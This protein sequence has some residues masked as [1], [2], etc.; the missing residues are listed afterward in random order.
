M[1]PAVRPPPALPAPACEAAAHLLQR[2]VLGI[3]R[4]QNNTATTHVTIWRRA[5]LASGIHTEAFRDHVLASTGVAV[6]IGEDYEAAGGE[7]AHVFSLEVDFERGDWDWV[8]D[9][10]P[11]Q[12]VDDAL[13]LIAMEL[14]RNEIVPIIVVSD[15]LR[16]VKPRH[17]PLFNRARSAPLAVAVLEVTFQAAGFLVGEKIM[18]G[19]THLTRIE[20]ALHIPKHAVDYTDDPRRD[21]LRACGKECPLTRRVAS[22]P[23]I[24]GAEDLDAFALF[25]A[26]ADHID[27]SQGATKA[28]LDILKSLNVPSRLLQRPPSHVRLDMVELEGFGPF[29]GVVRYPLSNRGVRIVTGMNKVTSGASSN[30]AGKTYL[31][32]AP[33]RALTGSIDT[34]PDSTKGLSISEVVH[35]S[36]AHARVRVE[37]VVNGRPSTIERQAGRKSMLLFVLDTE[38]RICQDM[39]LTQQC[40]DDLIDTLKLPCGKAECR[41]SPMTELQKE[42]CSRKARGYGVEGEPNGPKSLLQRKQN[43]SFRPKISERRAGTEQF[44]SV[45]FLPLSRL[46]AAA[47]AAVAA[48]SASA[49]TSRARDG[50]TGQLIPLNTPRSSAGGGGPAAGGPPSRGTGWALQPVLSRPPALPAPA[51]QAAAHLLQRVVLGIRRAQNDTA[52]THV[53]IL[54]RAALASRIHMEAF[55]DH[56]LAS[57]GVAVTIGEDYEAAGGEGALV[58]SLEVDFERG[59][60]DWVLDTC[61]IQLVDDAL[62]LIAMELGRVLM[63]GRLRPFLSPAHALTPSVIIDYN[64]HYMRLVVENA[65]VPIIAVS[66]NLRMVKPRHDPLFNRARS[67]PL[68]VAV[69]EVTFQ[70]AGFLVGEKSMDGQTNLTR[71]EQALDVKVVSKSVIGILRRFQITPSTLPTIHGPTEAEINTVLA[72]KNPVKT[73]K[74]RA[75]KKPSAPVVGSPA[76]LLPAQ[77]ARPPSQQQPLSTLPI[78]KIMAA[79][80]GEPWA[81]VARWVVFSDLHLSRRTCEICIQVLQAVH[82]AAVAREAGIIFLGDFWHAR[83]ALPVEPLNAALKELQSWTQPAIFITGNHDQVSLGGE[84][85]ALEALEAAN[86]RILVFSEPTEYLGALW[87]PYRRDHS[88]I[89]A[90][91]RVSSSSTAAVKAVLCHIDVVGATINEDYQAKEGF[92][93]L[94]FP[95]ELLIY[96]GHYHKPHKVEQTQIEYVGSPYQIS[97]S[98]AGQVKRFMVLD[99]TWQK[100]EDVIVNYGPR[101]FV[102]PKEGR[103]PSDLLQSARTGDREILREK[104]LEVELVR[105]IVASSPRITDAEDLDAFALFSAYADHI[106]L[107][108][109]A[110]KAGLDILKSLNVPRTVLIRL[111]DAM[112]IELSAHVRL[113]MVELEGFGPF[114]G[115][116]RYPLSNRGVRIVTGMNKDTSGSSSNGAGKT[117][118]VMAPLWALTGSTDTRP[119]SI[120]GLSTSEVV[121]QSS[122]HARVRVEGFVNGSPFTVERQAGRR[123]MLRFVLDT[124]ER[125]CQDMRLTQQCIDDLIDT[126]VLHQTVFHGQHEA[127]GLLE[128]TDKEFKDKL[129]R[130]VNIDVWVAAKEAS[131]EA[132]RDARSRIEQLEGAA[133]QA[134]RQISRLLIQVEQIDLKERLW[135]EARSAKVAAAASRGSVALADLEAAATQCTACRNDLQDTLTWLEDQEQALEVAH[136]EFEEES[137]QEDEGPSSLLAML[138]EQDSWRSLFWEK[139]ALVKVRARV[140]KECRTALDNFS[141]ST[142]G[143]RVCQLCKQPISEEHLLRHEAHLQKQW[144]DARVQ[145]EICEQDASMA[146]GA[147]RTADVKVTHTKDKRRAA[148]ASRTQKLKLQRAE[149]IAEGQQVSV[150]LAEHTELLKRTHTHRGVQLPLKQAHQAGHTFSQIKSTGQLD[151]SMTKLQKAVRVAKAL[152]EQK[153][154][155][156]VER[157]ALEAGPNPH[158]SEKELLQGLLA[159]TE[160]DKRSALADLK[161]AQQRAESLREADTSFGHNGVQG[162]ILEGALSLLQDRLGWYLDILSGGSLGLIL[163]P[164]KQAK[165]STKTLE[166]IEKVA[167]VRHSDGRVVERSLRQLSGGERRRVGLAYTLAFGELAS[168]KSGTHFDLMVLD[169]VL[170]HLDAEGKRRMVSILRGLAQSTTLIVS[171][172]D[173]ELT[174]TFDLVD[175]VVKHDGVAMV[176]LAEDIA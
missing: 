91:L 21:Q 134:A 154:R 29:K 49:W 157:L 50:P 158:R 98:E 1:Q 166:R 128:S 162:Y 28:G 38:E 12:L 168:E 124:E 39:R 146:L 44:D 42:G 15:N 58:F 52:T 71:I 140:F 46:A 108:Q 143:V 55:R 95:P 130:L 70:A 160:D 127:A 56:V 120:R 131:K 23:R 43:H 110:T 149:L 173:N 27:L 6:T 136:F 9:T 78:V 16:M 117:Y 89:E 169:E 100:V 10:C 107:S 14:G 99:Q 139:D 161:D 87:L 73:R 116:V 4:A 35:Q 26:F 167:V 79:T 19:Q 175:V 7:G 20:Q 132:L 11:I 40:I 85:H 2:V 155:E 121:H 22:S 111:C 5:A 176:A 63:E 66:D 135:E 33:L 145:L 147:L 88:L 76:E 67:A 80:D 141:K 153:K 64:N 102:V 81:T 101:H 174:E 133:Q 3:R 105:S 163:R 115:V 60:W 156:E 34:R 125:T 72:A 74:R 83:G 165:G 164:T 48:A 144:D 113:D 129:S 31:V 32:M 77:A 53:T 150:E 54:R 114:K 119:D 172:A 97:A 112:F 45:Q 142:A 90:S 30:G 84:V 13:R 148:E 25:S 69:L 118:L 86:E 47:A 36:G 75:A 126:S 51:F 123:S 37:G 122:A 8:L 94:L 61:P 18:D 41:V 171:Q 17:D 62:R 24:A 152:I 170:Q 104:G 106:N 82:A 151:E 138:A 57:T 93:P 109:G 92:D 159:K 59:D 96:T 68:A 103:L 65:S 137:E